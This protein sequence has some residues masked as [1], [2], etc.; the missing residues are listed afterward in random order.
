MKANTR[1][2]W[3]WKANS[4]VNSRSMKKLFD[5]AMAPLP[6]YFY[7]TWKR[8]HTVYAAGPDL[9]GWLGSQHP[10]FRKQ[11]ERNAMSLWCLWTEQMAF[12]AACSLNMYFI[13]VSCK[14]FFL[15]RTL[16]CSQIWGK[17]DKM[18]ARSSHKPCFSGKQGK[19]KSVNC[20]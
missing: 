6:A 12:D 20:T 4:S 1:D 16:L 2:V 10:F 11:A 18:H 9:P 3:K 17:L 5:S 13:Q 15:L 8:Q 7:L 14:N 19:Q